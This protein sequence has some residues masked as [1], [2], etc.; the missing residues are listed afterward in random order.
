MPANKVVAEYFFKFLHEVSQHVTENLMGP[1]NLSIVFGPVTLS[2]KSEN[3]E[4]QM[5][6]V[7]SVNHVVCTL[8]T[9]ANVI[10]S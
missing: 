8:I 1:E 5:S 3:L 2:S 10:F 7:A 9:H 6:N 4:V